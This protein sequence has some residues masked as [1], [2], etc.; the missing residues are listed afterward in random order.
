MAA[1]S[2]INIKGPNAAE[3][4]LLTG[5]P[6]ITLDTLVVVL[7]QAGVKVEGLAE[8]RYRLDGPR[9]LVEAF[10]SEVGHLE[11]VSIHP[12]RPPADRVEL[13]AM[14]TPPFPFVRQTIVHTSSYS[15]VARAVDRG[16]TVTPV[17]VGRFAASGRTSTQMAWLAAALDRP[18]ADVLAMFGLT[19]ADVK[20][21]DDQSAARVAITVA[22]PDRRSETTVVERD[23]DGAIR[24][25]LT[26]AT[27]TS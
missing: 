12:E 19:D 21:E 9:D 10:A 13:T 11:G 4:S 8:G 17:G 23:D 25:T 6:G 3:R 18:R 20:R 5:P 24:K 27:S 2:D 15:V 26:L 22:W 1:M 14:L 16:L 7:L